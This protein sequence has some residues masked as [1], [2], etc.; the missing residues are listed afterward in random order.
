MKR[1]ILDLKKQF[2]ILKKT[3][4]FSKAAQGEKILLLLINV[5]EEQQMEIEELKN[6]E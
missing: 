6:G 5:I 3:P 4:V 2:A 1:T